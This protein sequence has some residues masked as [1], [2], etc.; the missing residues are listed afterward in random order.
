MSTARNAAGV[1][2]VQ[3]RSTINRL[4]VAFVILAVLL[5]VPAGRM[6]WARGWIFLLVFTLLMAASIVYFTHANPEMF[7]V[8]S[9]VH[10]DTKQ[11][12]KILM[13]LLFVAILA[14]P[15]VAGLDDGRFH[16]SS[17]SSRVV[18]LGYLVQLAGWIGVAWAQTVNRFFEPGVRIQTERGHHVID[19]GPYALI[20]HPGYFAAVLLFVGIALSLG[21]W[22]ALIPAG[23]GSLLLVL[24]TVWEDRTLHAELPG[25]AEY[26]QRVR[27]RLVPGVW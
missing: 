20:R 15:P 2:P 18:A 11:W 3:W 6:T 24:R 21:S 5:F 12:D 7:A 25:Y 10:P 4:V 8:R 23:F 14:I 19:T 13:C 26:A 22:W 27:F 17:M 16:W 1:G 9:R